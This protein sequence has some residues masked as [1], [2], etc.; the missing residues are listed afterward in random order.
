MNK[1]QANA[2]Y[3]KLLN[4]KLNEENKIIE[5]AKKKGIW[6]DGLDSNKELFK[7]LDAKF[8]RDMETL[9]KKYL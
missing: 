1:E 6:R 2:E 3:L 8:E 5:S 4:E 7:E 9:R